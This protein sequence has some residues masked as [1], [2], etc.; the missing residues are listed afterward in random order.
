[1]P[2]SRCNIDKKDGHKIL[3]SMYEL[4]KEVGGEEKEMIGTVVV[5]KIPLPSTKSGT[6]GICYENYTIGKNH[7]G[8]SFLFE[9][10]FYDG[11]S[12]PDMEHFLIVKGRIPFSYQF[13]N[14]NNFMAQFR[15]GQ[16]R[17]YFQMAK[18]L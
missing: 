1:M 10:G 12:L 9:T 18:E 2:I 8:H 11:F 5:N 15:N 16:F 14:V 7:K 17:S 3:F 4:S 6:I 13:L